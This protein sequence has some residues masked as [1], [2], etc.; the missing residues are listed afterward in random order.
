MNNTI[1]FPNY[2]AL[3]RLNHKS[4]RC[5]DEW[6]VAD[7]YQL[8]KKVLELRWKPDR[9]EI[10]DFYNSEKQSS[11][12]YPTIKSAALYHYSANDFTKNPVFMEFAEHIYKNANIYFQYPTSDR[13]SKQLFYPAVYLYIL[14]LPVTGD[15]QEHVM[16]IIENPFV[17]QWFYDL[18]DTSLHILPRN[19]K[20][21]ELEIQILELI[22]PLAWL[23]DIVLFLKKNKVFLPGYQLRALFQPI[24]FTPGPGLQL[25][26]GVGNHDPYMISYK[27]PRKEEYFKTNKLL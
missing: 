6:L 4:I 25:F 2:L 18:Y 1:P 16:R 9:T 23:E 14:R 21:T 15:N 20:K 13:K 10:I 11:S 5:E 8:N 3:G 17:K 12:T 26:N 19:E 27:Q 24:N 7:Y 22:V